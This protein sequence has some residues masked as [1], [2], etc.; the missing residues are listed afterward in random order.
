MNTQQLASGAFKN[1]GGEMEKIGF[2]L[3]EASKLTSVSTFT[4]R[5][6]IKSGNLKVAR[7]G[8]RVVIPV[9]ELEKLV[10]PAERNGEARD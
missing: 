6:Q 9:A 8:R 4:L 5:R 1:T 7:V 3:G 2:S 10:R